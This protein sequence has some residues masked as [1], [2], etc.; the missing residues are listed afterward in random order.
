MAHR[1]IALRDVLGHGF[2]QPWTR[3]LSLGDGCWEGA[4][5]FC[6]NQADALLIPD[7]QFLESAG[8][9]DVRAFY[10]DAK[11][12]AARKPQALWRESTTGIRLSA[13]GV[14]SL[15][16]LDL[17]RIA[18]SNPRFDCAIAGKRY[19]F[20]MNEDEKQRILDSGLVHE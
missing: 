10:A 6:S 14:F 7:P 11:P 20:Q 1:L 17:C 16:R 8:Y 12:W 13:D 4:I 9:A 2:G 5:S 3:H 15:P 19:V 18:R